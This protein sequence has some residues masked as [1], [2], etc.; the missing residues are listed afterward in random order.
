MN[1]WQGYAIITIWQYYKKP[2]AWVFKLLS[3]AVHSSNL[4]YQPSYS[5]PIVLMVRLMASF[6]FITL[7]FRDR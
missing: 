2:P 4:V 5:R 3:V 7:A 1:G 6:S